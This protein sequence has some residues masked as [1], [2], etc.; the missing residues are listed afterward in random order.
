MMPHP[1]SFL[2]I[3]LDRGVTFIPLVVSLC[4]NREKFC[5]VGVDIIVQEQLKLTLQNIDYSSGQEVLLHEMNSLDFLPLLVEQHAKF[6]LILLDG[7]HNYYTVSRE[8]KLITQLVSPHSIVFVDD[9]S[10]RHATSDMWYAERPGYERAT[11]A[12]MPVDT[13]KH[14]VKA[15][16][17]D[18]VAANAGW[19]MLGPHVGEPVVLC[20]KALNITLGA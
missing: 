12:T 11:N 18:F 10:G 14:G 15:A 5:A 6:D 16:V 4:R 19:K 2:E 3:G 20:N 13:D 1:P 7:D 8:L 17:D 9:Y